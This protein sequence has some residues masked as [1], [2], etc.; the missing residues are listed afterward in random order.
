MTG[1]LQTFRGV[2][3]KENLENVSI[4]GEAMDMKFGGMFFDSRC[5]SVCA[6][7]AIHLL[8]QDIIRHTFRCP[9]SPMLV[10]S[11]VNHHLR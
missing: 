10:T 1:L 7:L 4:F 11:P 8:L 9:A 6:I 3:Q 5:N 2:Y